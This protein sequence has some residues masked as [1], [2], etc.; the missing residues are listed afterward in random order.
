[1]AYARIYGSS[2]ERTVALATYLDRYN[3]RRPHGSL[4]HHPPATR[5]NNLVRN[6]T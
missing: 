4:G 2:H 1:M 3:Y 6:Y 5:L